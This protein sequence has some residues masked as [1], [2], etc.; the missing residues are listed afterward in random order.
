DS[1]KANRG[2]LGRSKL[3]DDLLLL[4]KELNKQLKF[5]QRELYYREKNKSVNYF[6]DGCE[7]DNENLEKMKADLAK[8]REAREKERQRHAQE[9]KEMKE[10]IEELK[11]LMQAQNRTQNQTSKEATSSQEQERP[12][13]SAYF[14]GRR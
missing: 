13:D 3:H 4:G 8:E 5:H 10:T 2:F 7:K 9:Q 6:T 12:G 14:F 1:S 11:R